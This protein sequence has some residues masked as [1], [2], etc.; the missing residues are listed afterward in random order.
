MKFTKSNA[1]KYGRKGGR[2]SAAK[3]RK[4]VDE[5]GDENPE[6]WTAEKWRAFA[7]TIKGE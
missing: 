2:A 1:K 4:P 7:K 6:R 5:W 3:R